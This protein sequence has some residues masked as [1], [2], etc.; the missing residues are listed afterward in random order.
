MDQACLFA[1]YERN[2]RTGQRTRRIQRQA[3]IR[4]L[5]LERDRLTPAAPLGRVLMLPMITRFIGGNPETF[6][7]MLTYPSLV[8]KACLIR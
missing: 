7:K 8:L 1:A 6:N 3:G 2:V 5:G 4:V